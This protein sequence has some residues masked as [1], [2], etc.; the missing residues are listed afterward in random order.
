MNFYHPTY[1]IIIDTDSEQT[2][3]LLKRLN[4]LYKKISKTKCIQC[5]LKKGVEADCCK[6][7]SPP[8]HLIEFVNI[9]NDIVGESSLQDKRVLLND[10][11]KSFLSSENEKPCVL[12]KGTECSIYKTRPFAC[13]MFGQYDKDEWERRLKIFSEE[14]G[15]SPEKVP[16]Y[17]Q[18]E[19]VD[20]V[21]KQDVKKISRK[22]SDLL[23]LEL[24]YLD[25]GLFKDLTKKEGEEDLKEQDGKE[26]VFAS[27]TYTPFDVHLLSVRIGPDKLDELAGIKFNGQEIKKTGDFTA[28]LSHKAKVKDLLKKIEGG[29]FNVRNIQGDSWDC[30]SYR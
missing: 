18:C 13:R 21:K 12:L 22:K 23:Y 26:I 4:K 7:F 29:I 25:I 17:E 16:F 19:G 1:G 15:L 14:L 6:T 2:K 3:D 9:L 5:P 10:C 20:V 30:C 8:L 28:Y 24:H 27:M 11:F